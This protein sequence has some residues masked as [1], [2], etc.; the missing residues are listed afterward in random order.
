MKRFAIAALSLFVL[1]AA[2]SSALAQTE[3]SDVYDTPLGSIYVSPFPDS[4][5]PYFQSFPN[6]SPQNVYIV[7]DIDFGEIGGA[8]QNLTNGF[9]GWE[10]GV[11]VPPGVTVVGSVVTSAAVNLGQGSTDF[12]VGVGPAI[13]TAASTPRPL[14]T[15]SLLALAAFQPFTMEITPASTSTFDGLSIWLEEL[16]LNGCRNI[17]NNL[18]SPCFFLWET[19]GSMQISSGISVEEESWGGLKTRFDR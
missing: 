2:A 5:Y 15:L 14:V 11:T 8:S 4:Y 17:Q 10:G 9:R 19:E 6:F 16:T 18:P 13:I 3:R 12:I 1:G 7:A